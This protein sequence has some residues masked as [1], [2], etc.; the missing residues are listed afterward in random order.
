MITLC[1]SGFAHD[2]AVAIVENGAVIFAVEEER[3]TRKK[4][5]WRFPYLSVELALREYRLDKEDID[6]VA[7]YWDD[8]GSLSPAILAEVATSFF[9]HVHTR[10][11]IL[12]RIRAFRSNNTFKRS[13]EAFGIRTAR[14]QAFLLSITAPMRPIHIASVA[15]SRCWP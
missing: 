8:F 3:L 2:A 1:L 10:A 11:R 4:N 15:M 7:F 12:R 6:T 14:P 13:L 5:E 9:K